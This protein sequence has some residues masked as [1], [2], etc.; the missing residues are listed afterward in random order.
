MI[1]IK[2]ACAL[3][4]WGIHG[5]R[6][7]CHFVSL[8]TIIKFLCTDYILGVTI[9]LMLMLWTGQSTWELHIRIQ[10][11]TS[12]YMHL[13][14]IIILPICSCIHECTYLHVHEHVCDHQP[15]S[16]LTNAVPLSTAISF[17]PYLDTLFQCFVVDTPVP[18]CL[19]KLY[20]RENNILSTFSYSL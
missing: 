2:Y 4:S 16:F 18:F 9:N 13:Y 7:N 15:L 20:L 19:H 5:L 3:A 11:Y 14:I 8:H 1:I 10:H 12:N 6:A 17:Y